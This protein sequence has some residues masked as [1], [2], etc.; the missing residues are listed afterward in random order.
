MKSSAAFGLCVLLAIPFFCGP[1]FSSPGRGYIEDLPTAQTY[2]DSSAVNGFRVAEPDSQPLSLGKLPGGV[3]PMDVVRIVERNLET[4]PEETP[5]SRGPALTQQMSGPFHIGGTPI[6]GPALDD[7]NNP[8]VAFDGSNYLVVWERHGSSIWGA[9]VSQSGVVLDSAGIPISNPPGYSRAPALAFDGTDYLVVWEDERN[10]AKY[11]IYG[12][13]VNVEG[14]VLDPAGIPISVGV[15]GGSDPALRFGDNCCLVV[16][17]DNRNWAH[18]GD[19]AGDIYGARV[20][21]NGDVLDTEGIPIC[22]EYDWIQRNPAVAFDGSSYLVVWEDDRSGITNHIYGSRVSSGGV[23]LDSAG[24]TIATQMYAHANPAIAFDGTN[25]MVAWEDYRTNYWDIYASRITTA[26]SV[27]D[28]A[29]IPVCT[30]AN[31]QYKPQLAFDGTDYLVVWEDNRSGTDLDVYA[32]RVDTDGAVLDPEGVL[33]SQKAGDQSAPGIA[34]GETGW[35]VVWEDKSGRTWDVYG[36][37]V[38][39]IAEV[40]DA[41]G[42]L[43]TIT[44]NEQAHPAVAFD[45]ANYLVVWQDYRHGSAGIYGTRVTAG[46]FLLDPEGIAISTVPNDQ[47]YPAVAFGGSDYLVVWQDYRN[48][49]CDIYGA[50]VATDGVVRDPDGIAISVAPNYQGNPAVAFCGTNYLVVWEDNPGCIPNDC[51]DISGAR[52]GLDGSMLDTIRIPVSTAA[53]EQMNP[54]VAFDG[55]NYLVVWDDRRFTLDCIWSSEIYGTRVSAEGV[56]LDPEGIRITTVGHY[57]FRP[58]AACDGTECLVAWE[59]DRSSGYYD[60]WGARLDAKGMVLDPDGIPISLSTNGQSNPAVIF[61]G[62]GYLVAWNERGDI[63]G[64][65]MSKAGA[66]LD[67]GGIPVSTG[68]LSQGCAAMAMGPAFKIMIAHEAFT[69]YPYGCLRVWGDF[70]QGP[71]AIIISSVVASGK[72]GRVSLS[73]RAGSDVPASS[74]V[75][76]RAEEPDGVFV[77]ADAP[78]TKEAGLRFSYTDYSVVP[79]KT[80]WYRIALASAPGEETYGPIEVYVEAVPVTYRAYQSY[81]NPFNPVCTIRYDIPRAGFVRLRVLAVSGSTVRTLVDRWKEPGAYN[82]IWDG[83]GDDGSELP[84]GVYFYRLDVGAFVATR[85]AVLLR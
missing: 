74:F 8:V 76:E 42:I 81:P 84:S 50:R 83:R 28:T 77:K 65:R 52:V 46:G 6:Y 64:T 41:E 82:E 58:A 70:W 18:G 13:R 47:S 51:Q 56:V 36:T 26:G 75:I 20:S 3:D 21:R 55:A 63:W 66:V 53:Y 1:L 2:V 43:I 23:V 79:G 45:G 5:P 60:I 39:E 35:F 54:S 49:Q 37:R 40:A 29:G 57:L 7:Q 61:D 31:Q 19:R 11:D 34:Y 16:W 85:K 38:T 71:T 22:T 17:R 33:I 27:I 68:P 48:G 24:I 12:A 14:V 73:W 44:A 62:T 59:D 72:A 25:Y 15:Y 30:A 69:F 9:R 10:Y 80:Y 78:V 32:C 4:T 67:P